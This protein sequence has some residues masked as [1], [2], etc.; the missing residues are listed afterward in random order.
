MNKVSSKKRLIILLCLILSFPL[1][2]CDR[3]RK[4][5]GIDRM[6]E[7]DIGIFT[8]QSYET[9]GID[10][11]V[12]IPSISSPGILI[13]SDDMYEINEKI[14]YSCK[15]AKGNLLKPEIEYTVTNIEVLNNIDGFSEKNFI[16][17]DINIDVNSFLKEDGTLLDEYCF[18]I[19][20]VSVKYITYPYYF[21]SPSELTRHHFDC[22]INYNYFP[23][24]EQIITSTDSGGQ[25]VET[26][27]KNPDGS[28]AEPP[29]YPIAI[30]WDG[31]QI[32]TSQD[33]KTFYMDLG[34][35]CQWREGAIVEKE[36]IKKY[37]LCRTVGS[38]KQEEF[39]E[40]IIS[41][42]INY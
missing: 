8:D 10:D 33:S 36:L 1:I 40:C 28:I 30:Y 42:P 14:T 13:E 19:L 22:W 24:S 4:T 9:D 16:Y 5:I 38:Q 11:S 20:D 2:S 29:V 41:L 37:G 26:I 23:A 25:R 31:E 35:E 17:S 15:D 3:I 6:E 32:K 39:A 18:V 27:Y 21:S 7:G 34:E 12:V